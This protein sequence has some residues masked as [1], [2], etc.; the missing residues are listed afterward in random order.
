MK[1][2]EIEETSAFIPLSTLGSPASH[3]EP[4]PPPRG[5]APQRPEL[6]YWRSLEEWADTPEFREGLAREFAAGAPG[7]WAALSRRDFLRVMGATLA[8]AGASGCAYQPAEKIVPYLRQ[9]EEIVPGKPLFYTTAFQKGGY[10][11]GVLGESHMGRPTKIEGNPEHPASL[12][13]T[14]TFAQASLL[15]LYDPDRS[16]AVRNLGVL[17]TWESFLGELTTWLDP[18]RRTRGAGLRLLVETTTSP[19]LQA[20]LARLLA[21]YPQARVY[22]HDPAGRD[23]VHEGARLAFGSP[24]HPVYHL[25]RAERILS[26]DS[27]FLVD[28]PGSV[29]YARDFAEGRRVRA[30]QTRMNRLYVVESAATTTGATAEHRLTLPPSRI[31]AFARALAAALGVPGLQTDVPGVPEAFIPAVVKDLQAHRG[32]SLVIA[33]PHQPASVHALA[34]AMN[35]SLGNVGNTVTFTEPV[36][37]L[38][39]AAGDLRALAQEMNAGQVDTLFI[40]G[41]N[42]AYTAPSD[43]DFRSALEKVARRVH[44]GAYDDETGIL[45]HW[46][47]PESHY[48]EAWSDAR[49]YDGTAS[50]VQPL[51]LP[52]YASRSVHEVLAALLGDGNVAGYD[53][54]R[55]Y[56]RTRLKSADFERLWHRM[57][58]SGTVPGTAA[59][60]KAVTARGDLPAALAGAASPSAAE[61]SLEVAFRPD[62]TIGDGRWANN[63][64]LQE[65]PKPITSITWDNPAL[66]SPATARA[67]NL[68]N[69]DMI[70]LDGKLS[71]PVWIAPGQADG[72]VV[73]SL[74]YGRTRAG[75]IGNRVGFNAY[76]LR[77]AEALWSRTVN[78]TRTGGRFAV[79]ATQRHFNMEGRHLVQSV[80]LETFAANPR[81]P[82][83]VHREHSPAT[84]YPPVW[85]SDEK[86]PRG[87]GIPHGTPGPDAARKSAPG[88][89]TWSA[90]DRAKGG[91]VGGYNNQPVPAWGMVIDLTACVG[92]SSCV[93]ACQAENNIATVGKD[94][95]AMHRMMQ[96]LRI[97]TYFKG[98]PDAPEETVFQPMLCQHCEK[99]PCEP[100]CPVEATTHSAEGINEMTYNRCIGTRYCQNNCPYKVRRF[101]YLQFSDQKTPTIQMMRNP[102]VTVRSRGVMEKCT[103]C[104]QRINEAR[105]EAE[106]EDRRI[107]DGEVL[108]A[109]QQACPTRAIWFGN[110]NDTESHGGRGSLVRQLKHEPLNYALLTELNTMPRTSYLARVRN[111]NPELSAISGQPSAGGEGHG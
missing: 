35:Q 97:D 18:L 31:E 70:D 21:R 48:L 89:G 60:R 29:R 9:P 52:L 25:D 96:W 51:I 30:D 16:Q 68:R 45:C 64:W 3:P 27:N 36:E 62:P 111:L 17:T 69:G 32:A 94:Q 100:V 28:E 77:T 42:P 33:G 79:A 88:V 95:V 15:A 105:I 53:I 26:L 34:F 1:S 40:L 10:A 41:G 109:C 57:L 72:T 54:V 81:D 104:I 82:E 65:L 87:E 19:T 22:R 90:E 91:R 98:S 63:G 83:H 59:P 80:A 92:C 106:K 37:I 102:D 50:I 13:A 93:L 86:A 99:A 75:R 6:P 56:W 76:A 74:G 11:L 12:G 85:P 39:T 101:N 61:G 43:V 58:V 7:E 20:Q 67:N 49:A 55:D 2:H 66:V 24:A 5:G 84:L 44:L 23:N 47:I 103:F 107:E 71:L 8:L 73:V 46:H 110:L 78:M 14:D 4:G 38:L 108:T